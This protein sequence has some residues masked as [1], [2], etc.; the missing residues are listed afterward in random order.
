[1]KLKP[2]NDSIIF[3]FLDEI[4]D[5]HFVTKTSFGLVLPTKNVDLNSNLPRWGKVHEVGPDVKEVNVGDL[6]LVE[7][8]RWTDSFKFEDKRYCKT[9]EKEVMCIA[10]DVDDINTLM[11]I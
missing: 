6:I 11:V 1:M 9:I 3:E 10:E 7:P 5:G 8:L 2:L 4:R